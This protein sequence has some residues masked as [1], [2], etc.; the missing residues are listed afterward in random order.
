[1]SHAQGR[2]AAVEE[3]GPSGEDRTMATKPFVPWRSD[4]R[5]I[6]HIGSND[7]RTGLGMDES[8]W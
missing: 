6:L 4:T 1:M 2:A 5:S 8:V 3:L 7:Q